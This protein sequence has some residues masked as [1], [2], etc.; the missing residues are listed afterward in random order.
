MASSVIVIAPLRAPVAVGV[1]VT[2]MEQD[3]VAGSDAPQVFVSAKSPELAIDMIFSVVV[4]LFFRVIILAGELVVVTSWPPKFK[5]VG[6]TTATGAFAV[7]V[8]VSVADCWLLG[9]VPVKTSWADSAD[10]TEGVK[11]TF[12]VHDIPAG[13]LT[14]QLPPGA[15]AK[16]VAAAGG[17]V[18]TTAMLA[19]EIAVELLFVQVMVCGAVVAPTSCVPKSTLAGDTATANNNGNFT[20]NASDEPFKAVWK[21]PVV[22]GMLAENVIPVM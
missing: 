4:P 13:R 10:A 3:M 11:V 6:V 17:F 15:M 22:G 18:A 1:N 16:S 7:P 8:P 12:T 2:L 20:T 19:M 5:L 21:A 9:S 14:A